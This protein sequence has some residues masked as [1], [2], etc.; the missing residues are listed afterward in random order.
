[1]NNKKI[2]MIVLISLFLI[3]QVYAFDLTQLSSVVRCTDEPLVK[4]FAYQL[5]NIRVKGLNLK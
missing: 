3:T 2:G 5:K 4:I 1:M